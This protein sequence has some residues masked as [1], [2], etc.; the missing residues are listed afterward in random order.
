MYC[1][2]I[3]TEKRW[4]ECSV[5]N[6]GSVCQAW[7][8]FK[9]RELPWVLH[10]CDQ[11]WLARPQ[12]SAR[13]VFRVATLLRNR[14]LSSNALGIMD[15]PP[16]DEGVIYAAWVCVTFWVLFFSSISPEAWAGFLLNIFNQIKFQ[17]II[18]YSGIDDPWYQHVVP[19]TVF[20]WCVSSCLK[21]LLKI[22]SFFICDTN[23]HSKQNKSIKKY[24]R[25]YVRCFRQKCI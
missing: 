25:W 16:K 24:L 12:E 23:N 1:T 19:N 22:R 7:V 13:Y 18:F 15:L 11:S 3:Y 10:V 17:N 5:H 4:F 6:F 21:P 8:C 2:S 14:S 20:I 9:S